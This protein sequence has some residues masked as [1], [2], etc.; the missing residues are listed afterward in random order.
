M[1][2]HNGDTMQNGDRPTLTIE[3]TS[4]TAI[5]GGTVLRNVTFGSDLTELATDVFYAILAVVNE[6]T[7]P[8][9]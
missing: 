1:T 4:E 5:Y 3:V 8:P 9:L 2:K 7:A 6:Q